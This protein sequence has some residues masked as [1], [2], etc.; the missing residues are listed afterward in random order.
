MPTTPPTIDPAPG[1]PRRGIKATFGN[2]VDAFNTW[3]ADSVDQFAALALNVFNNA[4]EAFDSAVA[5]AE[6]AGQASDSA[7]A[8][9]VSASGAADSVLAAAAI[10]GATMWT[11]GT[12]Y[13]Q[14]Q[15]AISKVTFR[16]YRK[17][18]TAAASTGGAVDPANDPANWQ[19]VGL[20]MPRSSRTSNTMLVARDMGVYVEITGGSFTQAFDT[21]AN[22]GMSWYCHV[23]NS[24]T[25][26]ITIPSSD[27]RTNWI[28][29]PGEVRLFQ[30]DGVIL[31]STVL[32]AFK[33]DFVASA[34]WVKPPGYSVIGGAAWH[35]GEAGAPGNASFPGAGTRGGRCVTFSLDAK[36][37][38]NSVAVQV[39]AST[40]NVQTTPASSS[41][42]NFVSTSFASFSEDG[43]QGGNY[44]IR[45]GRDASFAG[46]G[47]GTGQ[48]LG[49]EAGPGG[50]SKNGGNGGAG[51]ALNS[52]GNP[53]IAPG[54][55]GGGGGRIDTGGGGTTLGGVGARGEVRV[56]GI[57]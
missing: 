52:P 56:W 17:T 15:A 48:D 1:V 8:A 46:A 12:T 5:A 9:S 45:F 33:K 43:G 24:G 40:P 47:S 3:L 22:L 32:R 38:P 25:G 31:R 27:G 42:G 29:Y 23:E 19:V 16:T 30:C 49:I 50:T 44:E 7:A 13:Q 10:N 53:G 18:T 6:W 37:I 35:A 21:P 28:M 26:D 54:G 4:K 39:A 36:Q 55:A 57:A 51:G 14:Y 34:A 11:A 41:F 20:T 2:M